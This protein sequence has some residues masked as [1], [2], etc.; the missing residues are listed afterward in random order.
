[1]IIHTST[2]S[3]HIYIY[4]QYSRYS[5]LCNKRLRLRMVISACLQNTWKQ[6]E[7]ETCRG[8]QLSSHNTFSTCTSF[9]S[10]VDLFSIGKTSLVEAS[11]FCKNTY[12]HSILSLPHDPVVKIFPEALKVRTAGHTG[13]LNKKVRMLIMMCVKVRSSCK[14]YFDKVGQLEETRRSR[15]SDLIV[16]GTMK[17]LSTVIHQGRT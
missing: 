4:T 7:I 14:R 10:T 15:K 2:Y 13:M 11:H 5:R 9:E 1:M 3:I 6:N 17:I 12:S 16:M 8:D